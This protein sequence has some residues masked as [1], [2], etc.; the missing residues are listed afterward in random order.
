MVIDH[1]NTLVLNKSDVRA[2]ITVRK[3]SAEAAAGKPSK[4]VHDRSKWERRYAAN[5]RITDTLVVCGAVTLAQFVRFGAP[6]TAPSYVNHYVTAYSALSWSFGCRLWPYSVVDPQ[7]TSVPASRSIG[8]WRLRP[9]GLSGPS[10]WPNCS[11]S[12]RSRE[13]I[14]RWLFLR[15]SSDC[16]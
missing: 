13:A 16:C 12:F 9:F 4:K 7:G 8:E 11:L 5:I 15:A 1:R 2:R 10:L 6:A 14:S 3:Q